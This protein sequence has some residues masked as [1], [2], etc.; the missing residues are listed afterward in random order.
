M[1]N[2]KSTLFSILIALTLSCLGLGTSL[3]NVDSN[4]N[5]DAQ[6]SFPLVSNSNHKVA[7]F[8]DSKGA[9]RSFTTIEGAL[10]AAGKGTE[11]NFANTIYV[12]PGTNP[13]INTECTIA[14]KDTL[15]IPYEGETYNGRQRNAEK[16]GTSNNSWKTP[17]QYINGKISSGDYI[18]NGS[19]PFADSNADYVAYFKKN[20]VTLNSKLIISSGACL[21]IGGI[22]GWKNNGVTGQTSGKYC[23][24]TRGKG[25]SIENSGTIDCRGYIKEAGKNVGSTITSKSGSTIKAP[26]VFYDYRGGKYTASV[27]G[28]GT[29]FPRNQYDFP[30]FQSKLVFEYGSKLIGYVDLFTDEVTKTVSGITATRAARHNADDLEIIGPKNEKDSNNKTISHLFELDNSNSKITRKRNSSGNNYT[31]WNGLGPDATTE[32]DCGGDVEFNATAIT[33]NA[34][35]DAKIEGKLDFLSGLLKGLTGALNQTVKTDATDFPLPWNFKLNILSNSKFKLNNKMKIM[36]GGEISVNKGGAL[37][38]SG[39]MVIYDD[40]LSSTLYVCPEGVGNSHYPVDKGN[41]KVN[42]NGTVIIDSKSSFGGRIST[43]SR[44]AIIQIASDANITDIQSHEG[45]GDYEIKLSDHPIKFSFKDYSNSPITKSAAGTRYRNYYRTDIAPDFVSET[46]GEQ[47]L[48]VGETY[49]SYALSSDSSSFGWHDQKMSH[50]KFGIKFDY[51]NEDNETIDLKEDPN[52]N[53]AYLENNGSDITLSAPVPEGNWTFDGFYYDKNYTQP[54]K[55]ESSQY[56]IEQSKAIGYVNNN[57]VLLNNGILTIYAKWIKKG[58]KVD[59]EIRWY[60]ADHLA[61]SNVAEIETGVATDASKI[62]AI[63]LIPRLNATTENYIR[64]EYVFK[65][66]IVYSSEDENRTNLLSADSVFIPESKI[67]YVREQKF[68][69]TKFVY[70]TVT[71]NSWKSGRKTYYGIY[72]FNV[73]NNDVSLIASS[74]NTTPDLFSSTGGG[75]DQSQ[76]DFHP[77]WINLESSISFTITDRTNGGRNS[78]HLFVDDTEVNNATGNYSG[79]GTKTPSFNTYNDIFIK[80]GSKSGNIKLIVKP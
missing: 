47:K 14:S 54:L 35:D 45:T 33:I 22:L 69:E 59:L 73:S 34:A 16:G 9:T 71:N 46:R 25:A 61:H 60:S 67:N 70:L 41:G 48:V 75:G 49:T 24:I 37:E 39:K 6:K 1:R 50:D 18:A 30:N 74:P 79:L 11:E 23:Q 51:T 28:G 38:I 66:W 5:P 4:V 44:G 80:Y 31:Y 36:P 27:Y 78:V 55:E 10:N 57:G 40:S 56:I 76:T 52:S 7:Y 8:K 62:G 26:F 64:T 32:F 72:N 19:N 13:T 63:Y 21:Q 42:N 68:E 12:I 2:W 3:W 29:I 77:G 20:E 17:V 53:V 58:V 43:D 15:C 65:E